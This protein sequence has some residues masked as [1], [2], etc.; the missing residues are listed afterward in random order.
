MP[1]YF[2]HIRIISHVVSF[3]V[4]RGDRQPCAFTVFIET[5]TFL[6]VN[7]DDRFVSSLCPLQ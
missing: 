6:A 3:G 1:E 5:V 2:R 4:Y 7:S